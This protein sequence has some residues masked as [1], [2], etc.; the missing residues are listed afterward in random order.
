MK[1]YQNA[2]LLTMT[3]F[4]TIKDG[5]IV[6]D[7]NQIIEVC[8]AADFHQDGYLPAKPEIIDL[9]GM[10]VMPGL[11]NCHQHSS[12]WRMKG[13]LFTFSFTP[14][15][16]AFMAQRLAFAALS[17]GELA[18]RDLGH[19]GDSHVELKDLRDRGVIL[20]PRIRYAQEVLSI[21]NNAV[22]MFCTEVET[23]DQLR[24]EI[25]RQAAQK[26]DFIK[27]VASQECYYHIMGEDMAT[28]WCYEEYLMEAARLCRELRLPLAVHANGKT[29]LNW[30]IKAGV[31]VIE[32]GRSISEEMAKQ[33]VDKNISYVPTM[34][35]QK[36]S[37][38]PGWGR[39]EMQPHFAENFKF[40]ISSVANAAKNGVEMVTGTDCL[41]TVPEEMLLLME[42]GG[43][44][45]MEALKAA[46]I[47]GAKMMGME[48]EI[49]S[50]EKG[51]LADF[52]AV[53]GDPSE[54][55]AILEDHVRFISLDGT[56][57][58]TNWFKMMIPAHPRWADGF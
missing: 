11:I 29:T 19:K 5:V 15:A 31:S 46:T 48:K 53:E 50:L 2:K 4:G 10:T 52:I 6:V 57:Y 40:L 43:L 20:A 55:P 16:Q 14:A 28:P 17:K 44:S 49:G 9:H 42:H 35:G 12:Y 26:T 34:S 38:T 25:R 13:N 39:D 47:K 22:P 41:G 18:Y 30:C 7:G 3:D 58:D 51:K 37:G 1:I 56:W 23:I 8:S 21:P 27:I 45:A 33:M 54:N 36:N 24:R 32:H